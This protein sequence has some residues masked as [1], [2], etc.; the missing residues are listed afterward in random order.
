MIGVPEVSSLVV[1]TKNF[2]ADQT[3][4]GFTLKF[5]GGGFGFTPGVGLGSTTPGSHLVIANVGGF[6]DQL[7]DAVLRYTAPTTP[8]TENI[9]VLARYQNIDGLANYY[10]FRQFNGAAYILRNL[11]G[12]FTILASQ[13]FPLPVDTDVNIVVSCIGPSLEATFTAVGPGTITLNAVDG[14]F[15]KGG[16]GFIAFASTIFC[17]QF[18]MSQIQ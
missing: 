9:A 11:N 18:N 6:E 2:I 7:I 3:W 8:G 12:V 10:E 1:T 4:P 15:T 5:N 13:A 14:T 17:S 16:A